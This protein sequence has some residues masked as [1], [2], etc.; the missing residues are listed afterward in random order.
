MNYDLDFCEGDTCIFKD[1]CQR[2][3]NYNDWKE[4]DNGIHYVLITTPFDE[5]LETCNKFYGVEV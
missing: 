1:K 2:F 4:K 5:Y 3:I